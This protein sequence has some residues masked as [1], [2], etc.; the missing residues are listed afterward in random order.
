MERGYIQQL[1]KLAELKEKG[2]LSDTE[3]NLK[4]DELLKP[5]KTTP[6]PPNEKAASEVKPEGTYWLPIPSLVLGILCALAIFDESEWDQDTINGLF[7]FA[8]IGLVLGIIGVSKQVKGRGMSIAGIVLS[9][10]GL[11]AWLGMQ[12][13]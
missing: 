5:Q 3:F 1:E 4:K 2:I 13:N 6:T 10:L 9:S 8:V 7:L 12:S 11:L